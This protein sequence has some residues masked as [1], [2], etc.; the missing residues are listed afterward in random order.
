MRLIAS[1]SHPTDCHSVGVA[2]VRCEGIG[3]RIV[4]PRGVDGNRQ[5]IAPCRHNREDAALTCCVTAQFRLRVLE[6]R[7]SYTISGVEKHQSE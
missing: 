6:L 4:Q 2:A 5:Q 1:I 7:T 3:E